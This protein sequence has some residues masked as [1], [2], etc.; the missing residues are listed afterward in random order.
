MTKEIIENLAFINPFKVVA[1]NAAQIKDRVAKAYYLDSRDL[2]IDP[3]YAS[4]D[5]INHNLV[6]CY[7]FDKKG[8]P[9]T[10]VITTD[11]EGNPVDYGYDKFGQGVD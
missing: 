2:Y 8:Y 4:I 11:E 9:Y 3:N 6:L 10:V 1:E 7:V 5:D